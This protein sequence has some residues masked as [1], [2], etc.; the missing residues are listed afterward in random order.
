MKPAPFIYVL[1]DS[2][3]AV[4][5]TLHEHGGEARLLAGGQ[6][7]IASMNFRCLTPQYLVDLNALPELNY[8]RTGDNGDLRIGAMTRYRGLECDPLVAEAAPLIHYSI[9]FIAHTAIRNRGTAGGSLAYADPAA[10]LPSVTLALGA[11][12]KAVSAGAERWIPAEDFFLDQ[13]VTAL[14]PEEVLTEIAIPPA[15]ERSGW[16]FHESARRHGDRVMMGVSAV[17]HL[18]GQGNCAS[19]RLVYQNG[20]RTPTLARRAARLLEGQAGSAEAIEAA[21]Q[22]AA[23]EELDPPDDVHAPAAYRRHLAAEL[24]RRALR[25]AFDRAAGQLARNPSNDRGGT[26]GS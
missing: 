15:P 24:T 22:A 13:F 5:D 6:S 12:Y 26:N 11:R 3:E 18:D 19:A 7:L 21:A 25:Q 8:I 1:P 9:P 4:V 14:T 10:E 17:V 23:Y 16:G 2:L 20:A